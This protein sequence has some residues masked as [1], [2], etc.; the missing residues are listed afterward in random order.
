MSLNKNEE[1]ILELLKDDPYLS[2]KELANKLS[3]SRPAIANVIS[4]LTQKGYI[5][6]KPYVLRTKEYITCIGGANVDYG[7]KLEDDIM[8]NTSNPVSSSSSYGGVVRN[9]AENLSR[10][11]E[12]VALMTLVGEDSVGNKLIEDMKHFM[13]L[14]S[15]EQLNNEHT[16]SYYSVLQPSGSMVVGFANMSIYNH[17]TRDWILRHKKQLHQSKWLIADLNMKKDAVEALIEFANSHNKPLAI[18]AVSSPKM[19][20]LPDDLEG[21]TVLINNRDE[22]LTY[23]NQQDTD[24]ETLTQLW[25]DKGIKNV[26]ITDGEKGSYFGHEDGIYHQEA[27]T[28]PQSDIKDVTGAGDAFSAATIFGLVNEKS[29]E[30]SVKF[31]SISAALTI[32]SLDAVNSKLSI[33]QIQKELDKDEK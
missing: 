5:L 7:F 11:N 20:N 10:L 31:G 19:K 21:V 6:G 25:L 22:S 30:D 23:F 3:L 18:V 13:A 29:L 24:M 16:G 12:D 2:Q 14:D 27:H 28:V 15:T 8:M 1:K 9:V 4:G 33:K 26:V 17:M 32:Q